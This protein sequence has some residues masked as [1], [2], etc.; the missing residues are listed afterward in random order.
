MTGNFVE[1]NKVTLSSWLDTWLFEYKKNSIR[2]S[3]FESYEYL[4]RVHLKPEI[5]QY[6][7]RE[8]R[9]E[10]IQT[11]YNKK[12]EIL[13]ARTVK[14][15]HI[16]L[17]QALKQAL[18][19]NLIARNIADTATLPKQEKKEM[20]VLSPEEQDIF[21]NT[22]GNDRLRTAFVLALG[23]GIR[24]G[25][26]LALKW[27]N[28][29]FKNGTI[30]IKES[31]RRVR[32]F[33]KNSENK[34]KIIFQEPKTSAGRRTIPV[35]SA[36]L[37]ELSDHLIR[38]EVERTLAEPLYEDNGLVFCTELGRTSETRNFLRKFYSLTKKSGLENV[39][40]HALRHTYATR[41]LEQN[42]HPKVLQVLLGHADITLTLNKYCHV[43]PD[44]KKA[45]ADSIN[46]LFLQKKKSSETEDLDT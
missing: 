26:L 29:D 19:N 33:D 36:V 1:T 22:L 8:L 2:P 17:N 5:G 34:T 20:R 6:P 37:S 46:N 43:I 9:P 38:Q 14:Y 7:L 3:T 15:I 4:V 41:L 10:H 16:V 40:F 35:P 21:L 30:S 13:S 45:A 32:T 31:V 25:E 27:E 24:E 39:N 18:K 23:T 44:I 11:L 12:T 28:V 42:Q